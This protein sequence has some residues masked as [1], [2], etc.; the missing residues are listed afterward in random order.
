[1]GDFNGDGIADRMI[2]RVSTHQAFIDLSV[3]GA[4]GNGVPDYGPISL[5]VTGDRVYVTDI[6]GDGKDDLAL[7][8]DTNLLP[9]PNNTPNLQTLYGYYNDGTGFS[10]LNAASPNITD[11]WGAGE[12]VL[13]G[14]LEPIPASLSELAITRIATAGPDVPFSGTFKAVKDGSYQIEASLNLL[15]PWEIMDTLTVTT[16]ALTNF[17]ISVEQLDTAFGPETRSKV[18][19][20]VVLLP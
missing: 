7:A 16:A 20:R 8:R 12:G 1:M 9:P 4:F 3:R 2:Y 19:V 10:T 6:N 11:L 17:S 13:F 5:G 15:S 18:F 14:N